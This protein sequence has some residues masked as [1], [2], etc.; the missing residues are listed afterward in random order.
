[1][2]N[3]PFKFKEFEVQQDRCAMKIGTDAVLLGSWSTISEDTFSILDVGAGTGVIALMMAQRSSAEVIDALEIDTEA[4]E[5]AVEN[6]EASPWG[7]RLFCYHASFQEF[8][9]EIEDEYDLIISNPPFYEPSQADDIE[10]SEARKMARFSD[11][12]PFEHLMYGVA[13]LLSERGR[14]SVVVPKSE[15]QKLIEIGTQL[16]LYPSKITRVKGTPDA[17]VKR[18]LMEFTFQKKELEIDVLII[19]T[20]RHQYTPEYI[21]LTKDFYLKM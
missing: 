6:F 2:S 10:M 5:Q 20:A 19:E 11:A 9:Q 14:F 16:E 18:S 12:L 8:F 15:E 13:N 4:Y 17:E 7:D 3:K 1:M 21:D